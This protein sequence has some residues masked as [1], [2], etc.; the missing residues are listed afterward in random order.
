MAYTPSVYINYQDARENF[1][2]EILR[3]E[4]RGLPP[5]RR[6]GLTSAFRHGQLAVT[7]LADGTLVRFKG[8]MSG[9]SRSSFLSRVR[10]LIGEL[11]MGYDGRRTFSLILEDSSAVEF[12]CKYAGDFQI[13]EPSGTWMV[14]ALTG[15]SFSAIIETASGKGTFNQLTAAISDK[16]S[17]VVFGANADLVVRP[18]IRVVNNSATP[19]TA[20]NFV[21]LGRRRVMRKLTGT[22]SSPFSVAAGQYGRGFQ[23]TTGTHTFKFSNAK[24]WAWYRSW[25]VSFLF[26][27]VFTTGNRTFWI[28]SQGGEKLVYNSASDQL[29]LYVGG[30]LVATYANALAALP[31]GSFVRITCI[32]QPVF[33]NTPSFDQHEIYIGATPGGGG[34]TGAGTL[35]AGADL[36]IGT[37]SSGGTRAE[38]IFDEFSILSE[39]FSSERLTK[40]VAL[41]RPLSE[42]RFED[43]L[44]YLDF[45]KEVN[46][47]GFSNQDLAFASISLAQNDSLV[48]DCEAQTAEK[49]TSQFVKTDQL[50]ALSGEFF[51]FEGKTYNLIYMTVTGGAAGQ[52]DIAFEYG[53][54]P[55]I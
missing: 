49:I 13:E 19:I 23:V 54:R 17:V 14:N 37:D 6:S 24:L 9:A 25:M 7:N 22:M 50:S 39:P 12:I 41:N 45:E 5:M 33:F 55:L 10:N 26:K 52:T 18:R 47:I 29:E 1:G 53:G 38:G 4:P 35:D 48:I 36:F 40:L 31:T 30:N 34:I 2:V 32:K 11:Q 8:Q 42:M 51:E 15:F 46:G 44:L 27:R 21:N 43:V 3:I 16:Q 20:V 28:T